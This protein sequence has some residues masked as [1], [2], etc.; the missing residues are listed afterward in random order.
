LL[1]LA[2]AAALVIFL[3]TR[4][5]AARER[6]MEAGVA[7]VWFED[8]RAQATAGR[9]DKAIDSFRKA[10][11]RD[12]EN[13]A[14]VLALAD[15][16]AD[17]GHTA[18][19]EETLLRLREASPE[20]ADINLRLARLAAKNGEVPDAVRYYHNA[21]YG[22]WSGAD[23][24]RRREEAQFELIRF[25]LDHQDRR[26]ALSE[27]LLLGRQISTDPGGQVEAGQLFLRAGDAQHALQHFRAA[28]RLEADNA[29]ALA[30]AGEAV[31]RLDD[32]PQARRD[33]EAALARRPGDESALQL[34]D[35]T[36]TV[37]ANDPLAHGLSAVE[38]SR[39][40][41]ADFDQAAARLQ[42]C[43]AL[44]SA[45]TGTANPQLPS[46]SA[47]AL[48][49]RG[50]IRAKGRGPDPDLFRSA[51]E[52]IYRVEEVASAACGEPAA[53]DSALLIIGRKESGVP[54][55]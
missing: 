44:Q 22:Q 29:D 14:Y 36:K 8:G 6:K 52:L 47:E 21:L 1:A 32:F 16:L 11:S 42:A 37:L 46:L 31:L 28:I 9:L 50:Q 18:E 30:G 53:L 12:Q 33:L 24:D 55:P 35:L 54:R 20:K 2:S 19:A 51:M 48:A 41:Q 13:V 10:T 7:A 45:G 49:M 3:F 27:L 38:R 4:D 25:L 39:R 15:A 23:A 26:G 40:L 5:M 34:L 17:A 43:W